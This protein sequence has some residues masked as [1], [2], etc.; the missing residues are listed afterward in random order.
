MFALRYE[1]Q[2]V[3]LC[4]WSGQHT[5]CQPCWLQ[6]DFGIVDTFRELVSCQQRV[7]NVSQ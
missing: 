2:E 3:M 1:S 4:L 5:G 6:K 7:D